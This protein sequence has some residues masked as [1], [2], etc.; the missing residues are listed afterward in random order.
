MSDFAG[1][2]TDDVDTSQEG[3]DQSSG[4]DDA[5]GGNPAWAPIR[6]KLGDA[7]FKLIEPELRGWDSGVQKRFDTINQ[8]YAPYKELGSPE[9]LAQY[10]NVYQNLDQTDALD[11][12]NQI[13]EFLK[14]EGRYP[15]QAEAQDLADDLE[16][17]DLVGKPDPRVDQLAASQDQILEFLQGQQAT[18]Q[19]AQADAE[20]G[21]EIDQVNPGGT[22][23]AK[24]DMVE[25]LQRAAFLNQQEEAK[26]SGK[27]IPIAQ[28]AAEF[29]ALRNRLLSAPRAVNSAPKLMPTSG[30]APTS[31]Q[32]QRTLG[33]LS[34]SETQDLVA[35]FLK[36]NNGS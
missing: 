21:Q 30:G 22:K 20:V 23:Y 4:P 11:L 26:G 19:A 9:E 29:D 25:I 31:G 6:E 2:G 5:S 24:D 33:S 3:S 35:G 27:Y 1:T 34:R 28:A 10:K 7:A 17:S 13:G 16:D 12:F 36:Q 32:P 15:T 8:Q 18:Q 14:T